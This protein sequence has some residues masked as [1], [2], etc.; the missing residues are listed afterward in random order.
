[1]GFGR[2]QAA[3]RQP[4]LLRGQGKRRKP[5]SFNKLTYILP[6]NNSR[7]E[8]QYYASVTDSASAPGVR[9]IV[10]TRAAPEDPARSRPTSLREPERDASRLWWPS[11]RRAM[12]RQSPRDQR[13][14]RPPR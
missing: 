4:P 8:P 10:R 3:G 1:M 2:A 12:A 9:K 5:R 13:K 7:E 11:S 14:A 6:G